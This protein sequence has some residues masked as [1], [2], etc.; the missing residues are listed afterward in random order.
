MVVLKRNL[1]DKLHESYPDHIKKDIETVIDLVIETMTM[2]LVQRR[3][4][5]IRGFGSFSLHLQKGR[6]FVNPKNGC[7]TKCPPN[8]RVVFKAG[9]DLK[10]I[11]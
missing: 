10:N 4:I 6:E 9:K 7:L 3:R 1:V 11:L 5:E 8:H 2:A